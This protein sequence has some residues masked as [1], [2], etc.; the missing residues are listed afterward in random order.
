MVKFKGLV[1]VPV[2]IN[3]PITS[4]EPAHREIIFCSKMMLLFS[5]YHYQI[6]LVP[7]S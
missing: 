2:K 6:Q 7:N 3:G 1:Y 4:G 5:H